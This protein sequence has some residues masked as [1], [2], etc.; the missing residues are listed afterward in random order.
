MGTATL[1]APPAAAPTAF[2]RAQWRML[3]AVMG[4]YL[5]YYT[6]RQNFGFINR[7][8]QSD[9]GLTP[10]QVGAVGGGMLLAYG[11]G[12]V[13]SGGLSDRYGT[14]V[15]MGLGALLSVAMNWVTSFTDGFAWLLLAWT[16]NGFAQSFGWSPGGRLIAVWWGPQERGRAFG[17]YTLAA[18]FSSVLTFGLCIG[19]LHHF[20]WRWV[21]RLP[22]LPLA[23][24]GVV[25]LL[26]ARDRPRDAG[27]PE[28][29]DTDPDAAATPT[30]TVRERY[31]AALTNGRFLLAC[32]CLGLESVGR[33]GLLFWVPA[34][35][36]GPDWKT[37]PGGAWITLALPAGMALGA[38]VNG[39]LSDRLFGGN[40]C[41]PIALFLALGAAAAGALYFIPREDTTAGLVLLFLAGFLVYGPQSSFWA[42]GPDLLG[43][44]RAGTAVGVMDLFAYGF[45]A[46]GEVVI[47][48]A[49]RET[50]NTAAVFPVVALC[51]L[52]GA[53]LIL[54][55]R[56]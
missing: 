4:C 8:L 51:C 20:D 2:R 24:A 36:L 27:F 42:I 40:R 34:H 14:R 30:E 17:F 18:G 44:S 55:V 43:R 1:D 5:F 10:D 29:D 33:Y 12:Q 56:R 7:A 9:L 41:R 47:G 26:V 23:L 6:G 32:V 53:V 25:F 45:A 35:Y 48:M 54:P 50:G 3:F 49:I 16:L 19:V 37:S 52:A 21:L 28:A 13:V 46:V 38:V 22:V 31:L 39:Q 15:L 11:L